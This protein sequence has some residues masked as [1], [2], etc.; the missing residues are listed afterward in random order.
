M[1][2]PNNFEPLCIHIVTTWVYFK[3]GIFFIRTVYSL[4]RGGGGGGDDHYWK[5]F[6][7]QVGYF[8]PIFIYST[9]NANTVSQYLSGGPKWVGG[10]G[11]LSQEK[12]SFKFQEEKEL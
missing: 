3:M 1:K 9:S 4:L 6:S 2:V 5:T 8:D 7:K 10:L 12:K 11:V